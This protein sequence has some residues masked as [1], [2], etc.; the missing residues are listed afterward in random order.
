MIIDVILYGPPISKATLG[1][2]RSDQIALDDVVH[3]AY[4]W[5]GKFAIVVAH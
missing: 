5:I 4:S 1:N 3:V 2:Q